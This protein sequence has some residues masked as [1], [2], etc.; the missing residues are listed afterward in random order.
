M[1]DHQPARSN[2]NYWFYASVEVSVTIM[3]LKIRQIG[4]PKF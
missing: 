3:R 1:Y 2:K 4:I